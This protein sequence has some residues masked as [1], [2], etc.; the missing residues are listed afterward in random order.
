MFFEDD[1][2]SYIVPGHVQGYATHVWIVASQWRDWLSQSEMELLR[3]FMPLYI[4]DAPERVRRA[5]S[6][7][8]HAFHAF[9]L[10]QRIASLVS[11][12]ESLLKVERNKITAQFKLRVPVLA[13]MV[14]VAITPVEA[15]K[16]YD[17]RSVYV[18]GRQP[19]YTDVSDEVMERYN[20]FETAIRCAL[21]RASIHAA[22]G[23]LFATDDSVVQ[24]FG[25]LA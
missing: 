3:D 20:R 12:F 13:R 18:H 25:S 10:D 17:D 14:G 21:F 22:F 23:D 1:V 4:Q 5:R 9:Y 2:L 16:L 11:S 8:D 24:T 7:I 6:H 19:N 15:E